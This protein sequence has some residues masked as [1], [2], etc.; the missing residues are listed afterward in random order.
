MAELVG[1]AFLTSFVSVLFDR[2]ASQEVVDLFHG[3]KIIV[4]QLK[5][6]EIMLM[7]ADAVLN[8]AEEKQMEDQSVRKWLDELKEVV[9]QADE[10]VDKL[11]NEALRRK[12]EGA[13]GSYTSK[14]FM[15]LNPFSTFDHVVK[16]KLVEIIRTL[17]LL[18]D[19]KDVLGLKT[20]VESKLLQR[21]PAPLAEESGVYGRDV[22]K[23][24]I[25][26]LL[27]VDDV[28]GN[29]ISVIPIVGMGGIGKTNDNRMKEYFESKAWSDENG[30]YNLTSKTRHLACVGWFELK[31]CA[32][33]SEAEC[34]HTFLAL[35][36]STLDGLM[37]LLPRA[38]EM[39][40][41]FPCLQVMKVSGC[42]EQKSFLNGGL[43]SSLNS[44]SISFCDE[45]ESFEG[46]CFGI[47]TS[48]KEVE[49]Y[50]C[51]KF[52]GWPIKTPSSFL[53][54]TNS[55]MENKE[56][57]ESSNRSR[58]GSVRR[59]EL[60]KRETI[61]DSKA[62]DITATQPRGGR[63]TDIQDIPWNRLS[64]TREQ[65]RQQRM[66]QYKN[67]ENVPFSGECSTRDCK[68]TEKRSTYYAFRQNVSLVKPSILHFQLRNLVWATSKHD[69]YFTSRFS[70]IHWSSLT[71]S[72]SEVLNISRHV[73]PSEKHPGSW[74]EGFKQT[75]AGTLAV[76]DQLQVVG[77][78]RGELIC[79]RL[80]W[81]GVSY[82]SKT[83]YDDNAI[84]NSIEIYESSSGA[85]HFLVSSNDCGVIEFNMQ[86]FQLSKHFCFPWSVNHS[87]LNPD[88]KLLLVV[89]DSRNG[90][91]VDSQTGKTVKDICGHLD[92][93]F[94]S[95][96]HPNG[97]TFATGNQDK[98]CRIWDLRN[99]SKSVDVLSGNLAA[100]RSIRFTSDGC[101][102]AMAE[103]AD[104][105]HVYDVKSGYGREQEI[106]FFGEISELHST[107]IFGFT[108]PPT[109]M[110]NIVESSVI[111]II[112]EFT[113]LVASLQGGSL[114]V[115]HDTNLY[116]EEIWCGI[117]QTYCHPFNAGLAFLAMWTM[118]KDFCVSW[119]FKQIN[120][121]AES[122]WF[123]VHNRTA[124]DPVYSQQGSTLYSFCEPEKLPRKAKGR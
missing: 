112:V 59:Y 100:I 47:P 64:I 90:L 71:S 111:R 26:K 109:S 80:D 122:C 83:T 21:L 24:A 94:A 7:S 49:I 54:W 93:S 33:L 2:F 79:K 10:L 28:S 18:V 99:L 75:T 103:A 88:G 95:A 48:L 66:E 101:Y 41:A 37:P 96:W 16:S 78:F 110:L 104:F 27:L 40:T 92:Y 25:I 55:H 114:S 72:R 50:D 116:S 60:C 87:S 32:N 89:G 108:Y 65:Y 56:I 4:D 81:P 121:T 119:F 13:S 69:V 113:E 34:L 73:A 120:C 105:I 8:D 31:K 52:R 70:I 42:P 45:L 98:T 30:F 29:E 107:L 9:Y 20:G 22:D 12:V 44:L 86:R 11:N 62:A 85:V 36:S 43:P 106:D 51:D 63:G 68:V 17:K 74:L 67:Y 3:D 14:L 6:L 5:D 91:L 19:R 124:R 1:G 46:E 82:C 53:S 61:W 97:L 117:H 77:G 57:G 118:W 115:P 58:S 39:D 15:K 35:Q 23:E 38:Q 123:V 76:K 102:M 84:A